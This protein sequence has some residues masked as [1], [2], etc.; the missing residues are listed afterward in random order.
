MAAQEIKEW[1]T[2]SELAK[3]VGKSVQYINSQCQPGGKLAHLVKLNEGRKIGKQ[4]NWRAIDILNGKDSTSLNLEINPKSQ[5]V[6]DLLKEQQE[7]HAA[8]ISEKDAQIK[9]LHEIING[10]QRT[11]SEMR[12]LALLDKQHL[13]QIEG[14][15]KN[16]PPDPD[17]DIQV[18]LKR[19]QDLEKRLDEKRN[20]AA[21]K[22]KELEE[23]RQDQRLSIPVDIHGRPIFEKC[24]EVQNLIKKAKEGAEDAVFATMERQIKDMIEVI[25]EGNIF[26]E[27]EK[28][29]YRSLMS[30]PTI[31]LD[32]RTLTDNLENLQDAAFKAGYNQGW[33]EAKPPWKKA[34]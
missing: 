9:N 6:L 23:L 31:I 22:E 13:L 7:I 28:V 10:C 20:Y 14:S 25:Q 32:E 2:V 5:A 8:Q 17:Q 16:S 33:N 1:Y 30:T 27:K 26:L 29:I 18:L 4:V 21:E 12:Q 15:I 19:I 24:A 11:D 34:R 3:E